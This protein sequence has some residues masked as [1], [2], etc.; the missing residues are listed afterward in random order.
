[1]FPLTVGIR[2]SAVQL[3]STLG[4]LRGVSAKRVAHCIAP[5]GPTRRAEGS[6]VTDALSCV[7]PSV[8][9]PSVCAWMRVTQ[10]SR[11]HTGG[12]QKHKRC[13]LV[14]NSQQML[15][16]KRGEEIDGYD[17]VMRLNQA[18]TYGFEEFVGNKT[19][20]RMIN[21][22]ARA[23]STL[24]EGTSPACAAVCRSPA[25]DLL[26]P[27]VITLDWRC[28]FWANSYTTKEKK[29]RPDDEWF[30]R[31]LAL[32]E[33]VTLVV[34]RTDPYKYVKLVQLL[35]RN[36]P[37]VSALHLVREVRPRTA[38]KKLRIVISK[39]TPLSITIRNFFI[40]V[41]HL[42]PPRPLANPPCVEGAI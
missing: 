6:N 34:S 9:R 31:K 27:I 29:L 10:L 1:V 19:T 33:G 28:S 12:A 8:A 37:D 42:L 30:T 41:P 35:M 2:D 26:T 13:T 14:G 21:K 39:Y 5:P 24:P 17:V 18:P 7:Y 20:F 11:A 15:F 36:R 22:C 4:T 25:A 16:S 23:P 32:E 3:V 38:M 40:A